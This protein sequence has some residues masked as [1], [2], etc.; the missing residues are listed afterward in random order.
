MLSFQAVEERKEERSRAAEQASISEA[1]ASGPPP[2]QP[3]HPPPARLPLVPNDDVL[4]ED[5]PI[6]APGLLPGEE[7]ADDEALVAEKIRLLQEEN[8]RLRQSLGANSF[9]LNIIT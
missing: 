2:P 4:L 8:V 9:P 3:D 5:A 7:M 1:L 6:G